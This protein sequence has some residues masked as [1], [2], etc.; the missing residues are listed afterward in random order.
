MSVWSQRA[1]GAVLF[2]LSASKTP[3]GVE[4]FARGLLQSC[5]AIGVDGRAATLI[6]RLR[7][8]PRLWKAIGDAGALVVSLPVVA[9]KRALLMP[10]LALL[11]A[12][13]RGARTIVVMHEWADLDWRRRMVI[14]CYLLLAETVLFSSPMVRAQFERSLIGWLPFEGPRADPRQYQSAGAAADD[15]PDGAARR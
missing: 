3:C 4:M 8:T 15:A 11:L 13:L 7:E 1:N 12:R 5:R 2:L 10:A 14:A 9:W 6:G